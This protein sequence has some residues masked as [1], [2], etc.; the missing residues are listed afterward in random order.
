MVPF[1]GTDVNVAPVH[2]VAVMADMAGVGF[3]VTVTV[4]VLPVQFP[5]N[6]VTV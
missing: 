5:D 3:T 2:A 1:T 4:K 6:G